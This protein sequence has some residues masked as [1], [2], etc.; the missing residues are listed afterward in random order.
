VS[1]E[2]KSAVGPRPRFAELDSLELQEIPPPVGRSAIA[3]GA[4]A[5]VAGV[6]HNQ[7]A[8]KP[9]HRGENIHVS[10]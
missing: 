10:H 1:G 3:T 7:P 6:A 9:A 4:T 5:E 2:T 8:G